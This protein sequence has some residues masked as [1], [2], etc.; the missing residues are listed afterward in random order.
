MRT[1][2]ATALVI[3]LALTAAAALAAQPDQS[4]P[5]AAP[6]P[7]ASSGSSTALPP[8]KVMLPPLPQAKMPDTNMPKDPPLA[9]LP[10]PSKPQR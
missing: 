9:P 1:T 7:P 5:A 10:E 8:G 6:P 4:A 3:P 2:L